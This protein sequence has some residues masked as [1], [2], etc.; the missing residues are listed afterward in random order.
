MLTQAAVFEEEV[1]EKKPGNKTEKP[2]RLPETEPE[3]LP[4]ELDSAL[5]L[6]T[7]T[8]LLKIV[9]K[10]WEYGQGAHCLAAWQSC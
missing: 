8:T 7:M 6:M 1:K 3:P 5:W 4:W 9:L 10:G 2:K